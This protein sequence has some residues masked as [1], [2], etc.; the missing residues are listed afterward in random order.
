MC[1]KSTKKNQKSAKIDKEMIS[2][3]SPTFCVFFLQ[4]FSGRSI[5][6]MERP[7]VGLTNELIFFDKS[8]FIK[9]QRFMK[10]YKFLEKKLIFLKNQR[11]ISGFLAIENCEKQIFPAFEK[12]AGKNKQRA[13]NKPWIHRR[14]EASNLFQKTGRKEI[15]RRN[16]R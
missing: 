2:L 7:L 6:P 12:S 14:R 10:N 9:I 15:P 3:F 5:V 11:F 13:C 16:S 1:E 8:E 4:P